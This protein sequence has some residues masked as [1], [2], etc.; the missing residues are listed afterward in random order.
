MRSAAER[1][2]DAKRI[3]DAA[4]AVA[5]DRA[6]LTTDLVATTGL[7]REGVELAFARHLELDPTDAEIDALVA[8]AG[9]AKHVV[10]ILSANVFVAAL[11]AIA[12]ARAASPS[13]VVRPSRREPHFARA[14]VERAGDRGLSL[15]DEVDAARLFGGEVHVYG[16]D[17]TIADVR[18][19]VGERIRVR[20]HGAGMGV[21]L[22]SPHASLD[23]AAAA[24]ASD[25]IAFDQRG[26]LSPRVAVVIGDASRASRFADALEAALTHANAR[27]PRGL[28]HDDERA[29]ASRYAATMAFAGRAIVRADHVV[30]AAPAGAPLVVPPSGRH[31]HVAPAASAADA[32]LLL[33]D[34][35]HVIVA[36]G[37]DDLALAASVAPAHARRSLLGEMQ[38]PR[39]DGP[40]D[41]RDPS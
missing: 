36:L 26:C 10:V 5:N 2:T 19:K 25:V 7:S 40:V 12:L 8:T 1:A 33:A 34:L 41:R 31:V 20:G 24:L 6:T 39:L 38:R 35:A 21:A 28:V 15:V 16:R 27:V 30:G 13:V 9:N 23:D 11:R 17:A 22:V 18:A 14:L 32:R 29:D 37:S 3:V 4:R